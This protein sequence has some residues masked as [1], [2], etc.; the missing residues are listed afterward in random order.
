MSIQAQIKGSLSWVVLLKWA[1]GIGIPICIMQV[2]LSES[3]TREIRLF[4]AL[5]V[6]MIVTV[7]LELFNNMLIPSFLLPIFYYVTKTV[8][9]NVAYA[10]WAQEILYVIIGAF[11][12]AAILEE[13]G[14]LKRVAYW[15]ILKFG[16]NFK[17]IYWGVFV[18]CVVVTFLTFGNAYVVLA[19]FCFGICKALDLGKSKAAALIMMSGL[20]GTMTSR[21]FIYSPQTVGLIETGIRTVDPTFYLPWYKYMMEMSPMILM[22]FVILFVYAKLFKLKDIQVAGGKEYF[23]TEYKNLGKMTLSEKKAGFVLSLLMVFLITSPFH[24]LSANY[25]FLFLP[26]MFFLPGINIGTM[27]SIKSVDFGMIFFISS[28][29]GIGVVGTFLG[30]GDLIASYMAPI[31]APLGTIGALYTMFFFGVVLNFVLT[32]TAMM[33]TLPAPITAIA[34]VIGVDPLALI[35]PFKIS[36]DCVF[37]PYE[38]VP[39]L[40]FFSFGTMSMADFIKLSSA[41]ILILSIGLLVV[42]IPFWTLI[43]IL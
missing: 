4:L 28:C 33:A 1:I 32:P 5:S 35:Y 23:Q 29:L 16:G 38:Y 2:P 25:A 40:I 22:C 12:M 36:T 17:G 3:F 20:V 30:V 13:V 19:T 10:S 15:C 41:K 31:M 21:Q 14:L 26:I 6:W 24:K 27:S 18:A 37:L 42:M 34:G 7:A 11:V 43:G 8:P 9:I 39:Y